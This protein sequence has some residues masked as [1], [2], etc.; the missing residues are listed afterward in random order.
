MKERMAKELHNI[1]GGYLYDMGE[2]IRGPFE[3]I[4][5]EVKDDVNTF[6]NDVEYNAAR[7]S[8]INKIIDEK[9]KGIALN[10]NLMKAI[11]NLP[12]LKLTKNGW[13][14]P[15]H[16]ILE[17]NPETIEPYYPV[18]ASTGHALFNEMKEP[19]E[20]KVHEATQEAA[21][22]RHKRKD[23]LLGIL[24]YRQIATELKISRSNLEKELKE[25]EA[26]LG[27]A[28]RK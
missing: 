12:Q 3:R 16:G 14:C 20:K 27:E 24:P 1:Y 15:E 21:Q 28:T 13:E 17:D 8:E 6:K 18:F 10:K 22:A 25:A 7:Y 19:V 4:L 23:F 9:S 2:V 5:N 11:V 26:V